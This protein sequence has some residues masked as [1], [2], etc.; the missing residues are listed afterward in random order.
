MSKERA[1][2]ILTYWFGKEVNNFNLP[3]FWFEKKQETD[4]YINQ[5]FKEDF[6]SLVKGEFDDWKQT[7]D[8]ALASIILVDQFTRNMFRGTS[9]SFKYD[10]I[11]LDIA[12]ESVENGFDQKLQPIQRLF[13][14]LPFEHSEKKENQIKSLKLFQ[15]LKDEMKHPIYDKLFDFAQKHAD[16]IEKM[17]R[18]P[19]RNKILGRE[20]TKEE[21]EFLKDENNSF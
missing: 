7:P 19:H 4:D 13:M 2:K 12:T 1:T 17:G 21:I 11:A 8:G 10:Q 14:Y 9:E 16:V 20:S 18:Y 15:S 3:S 6:K 5:H